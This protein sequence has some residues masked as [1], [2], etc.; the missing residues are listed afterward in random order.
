MRQ[1]GEVVRADIGMTFDG[2]AKGNGTVVFLN[3]QEAQNAIRTFLSATPP[4][5]NDEGSFLLASHD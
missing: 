3:P 1:A 2:R 4:P 5:L